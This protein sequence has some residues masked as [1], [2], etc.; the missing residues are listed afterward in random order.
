MSCF[1][2]K[3]TADSPDTLRE[4]LVV[5]V[6]ISAALPVETRRRQDMAANDIMFSKDSEGQVW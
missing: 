1:S 4:L 5:V 2:T 6:D 3:Q